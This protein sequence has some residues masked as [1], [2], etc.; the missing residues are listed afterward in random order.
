MTG[1]WM[2]ISGEGWMARAMVLKMTAAVAAAV[3]VALVV[4]VV[5]IAV[6]ATVMTLVLEVGLVLL[7]QV[8][9]H[10]CRC[11]NER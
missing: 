3:A 9:C 7:G 10:W 4:V 8:R 5:A 6:V 1:I 2:M 11:G